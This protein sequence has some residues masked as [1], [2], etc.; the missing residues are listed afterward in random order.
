MSSV[1]EDPDLQR[2]FA[3]SAV[4]LNAVNG[5]K[6]QIKHNILEKEVWTNISPRATPKDLQNKD[7]FQ[8]VAFWY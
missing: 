8:N 1:S 3:L 6:K 5:E 4:S 2:S 7:C